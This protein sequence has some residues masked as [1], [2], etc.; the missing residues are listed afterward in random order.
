MVAETG[1]DKMDSIRITD[2]WTLRD[3]I[4]HL[5]SWW[6]WRLA[7]LQAAVNREPRPDPPYPANLESIDE[8]NAWFHQQKLDRSA[9]DLTSAFSSSFDQ[10]EQ[11]ASGLSDGELADPHHILFLKGKSLADAITSGNFF[12]HTHVQHAAQVDVWLDAMEDGKTVRD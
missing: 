7:R 2:D 5:L 6:E 9:N 11:I 12:E 10:L 1:P 3:L 4:A 8:Q